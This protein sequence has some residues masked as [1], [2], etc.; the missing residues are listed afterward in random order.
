MTI[1]PGQVYR[2]CKPTFVVDGEET[3]TRIKVTGYPIRTVGLFG[4]DKVPIVTLLDD[5]KEV[6]P[7]AIECSELH[8]TRFTLAGAERRT[9]YY[10][11]TD[12]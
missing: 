8:D 12:E 5:G 7:R 6:R 11:E 3:H 1:S 10:L 2:S 4:Y 9:G